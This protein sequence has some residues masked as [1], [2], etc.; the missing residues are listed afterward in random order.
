MIVA[1]AAYLSLA[2]AAPAPAERRTRGFIPT[3]ELVHLLEAVARA[4]GYDD[5]DDPAVFLDAMADNG[6]NS[7]SLGVYRNNHLDLVLSVDR[8]TGQVY[9]PYRCRI[10]VSRKLARFAA[11]QQRVTGARPLTAA[12]FAARNGCERMRLVRLR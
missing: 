8:D 11:A 4:L 9:D 1:L 5:K 12:Y 2:M 3:S 6:Q 7:D 10:Y